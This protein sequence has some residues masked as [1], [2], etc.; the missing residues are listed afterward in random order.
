MTEEKPCDVVLSPGQAMELALGAEPFK[1][2]HQ[3]LSEKEASVQEHWQFFHQEEVF[4]EK[5]RRAVRAMVTYL[6]NT[7]DHLLEM[8]LWD[9]REEIIDAFVKRFGF[10]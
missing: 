9:H 5:H 3:E 1:R 2:L 4:L 7:N 10:F 8:K 6:C